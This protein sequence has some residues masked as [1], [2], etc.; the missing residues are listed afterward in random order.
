MLPF[1]RSP[2]PPRREGKTSGLRFG[3]F[4]LLLLLAGTSPARAQLSD[5]AQISLITI[6]PGDAVYSLWGHSALRVY[7]PLQNYDRAFNYGTF[8]FGNPLAFV[9]KFSYG[10]L[11][12]ILSIQSYPALA[13]VS[14]NRQGRPVIEQVLRLDAA[15]RNTLF[16]FL[17]NNALPEHRSYRYNFLFDNCSTRIRDAFETLLGDAVTF[18][19]EPNPGLSFRHLID[20]YATEHPFLDFGMDLGLG[21]PADEIATARETMFLPMYLMEAFDHA[22][23]TIDGQTQPLVARTDTVYW[24][25]ERATLEP[26]WPWPSILLWGLFAL[27]LWVIARDVRATRIER[28]LFDGLLFGVTGGAGLLIVFL[29]FISLHTVT[30]WNL[31]LLW[32]WPSHLWVAWVLIRRRRPR[33]LRGYLWATALLTLALALSSFFLPQEIPAAALPLLLLLAARS[34]ALAYGLGIKR[35]T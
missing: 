11:D 23:V 17:Q 20:P 5:E 33:R 15:Q 32:A 13:D 1:S 3:S 2:S 22:T 14:W 10:Q 35:E 30:H 9:A 6:L 29:W 31:N 25:A 12:Y 16:R 21:L 18:A 28:R 34:A 26:S 24:S 8:A 7:D 4:V 27:G 19:P